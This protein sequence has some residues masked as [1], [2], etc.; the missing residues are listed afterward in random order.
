MLFRLRGAALTHALGTGWVRDFD[1]NWVKLTLPNDIIRHIVNM[2]IQ[3]EE[4]DL[5]E[6][7]YSEG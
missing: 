5:G 4:D 2:M 1:G 6:G 7:Y 3:Q